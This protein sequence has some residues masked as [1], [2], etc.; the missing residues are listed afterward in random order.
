M[1]SVFD[2]F[3]TDGALGVWSMGFTKDQ[4]VDRC[5]VIGGS[6]GH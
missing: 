2:V 5:Q 1:T 3:T 4:W 6:D